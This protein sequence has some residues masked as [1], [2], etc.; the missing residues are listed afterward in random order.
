M[1]ELTFEMYVSLPTQILNTQKEYTNL[2]SEEI[3]NTY[4]YSD[5]RKDLNKC[6]IR[7]NDLKYL[8]DFTPSSNSF[9][10]KVKSY[11]INDTIGKFV[12][13]RIDNNFWAYEFYN[14]V[15]T[16]SEKLTKTEVFYLTE[17][18]FTNNTEEN[19]SE[20]LNISRTHLQKI[21]KSCLVKMYFDLNKFM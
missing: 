18:F 12:E 20:K 2:L 1:R 4:Y 9:N 21:K 6:F 19:I 15:L 3:I 13:K 16:L 10:E 17:T 8:C 11:T 7:F 14:S 5:L